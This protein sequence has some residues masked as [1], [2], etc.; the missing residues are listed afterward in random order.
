[1]SNAIPAL[2]KRP[3]LRALAWLMPVLLALPVG[4]ARGLSSEPVESANVTVRLVSATDA[5][6][7]GESLQLGVLLE[8]AP[9]WHTYW[10]NP[11]VAGLTTRLDWTLPEG[12]TAG[13]IA[14]PTPIKFGQEIE[15]IGYGYEGTV[16]L[17]V[18]ID[19]PEDYAGGSLPVTVKVRYLSCAEVCIPGRAEL[20]LEL[21][22]THVASEV[23]P[24]DFADR[25]D[26]AYASMPEANDRQESVSPIA[27]PED[28]GSI[29]LAVPGD[30]IPD[31]AAPEFLPA[32]LDQFDGMADQAVARGT[33]TQGQPWV[34]LRLI[35]TETAKAAPDQV[36]GLVAWGPKDA[37]RSLLIDVA[38]GSDPLELA[39]ATQGDVAAAA[40][41]TTGAGVDRGLMAILGF[42]V[43]GGMILNLMP[44]VFPVLAL[45]ISAFVG[46][47]GESRAAVLKHGLAFGV[48]VLVSFW[49]IAAAVLAIKAGGQEIGWGFQLQNPVFVGAMAIVIFAVG[50]N[51]A[52]VF[53]IGV[54]VMNAAGKASGQVESQ[55][56]LAGSF[57]S[58]V[59]ATALATPCSAPFLATSVGYAMTASAGVLIAVL[60]AMGVGM[61]L[62]YV[63][64]SAF[65]SWLKLL[66]R[67]GA[68]ME[69]FKQF[70][71]FPM[72]AVAAWLVWVFNGQTGGGLGLPGMLGALVL[73]AMG[74][75]ALGRFGVP[76]RGTATR[77]AARLA[78]LA[79]VCSSA[80]TVVWA[81]RPAGEGSLEWQPWSEAA[82]AEARAAGRPVFIDFTAD[83]CA[84]CKFNERVFIDLA[85][86][87][88]AVDRHDVAVFKADWTR[89]DE[90]I[91]AALAEFNVASVP[92]YVF[93]APE[94]GE[95]VV[96]FDSVFSTGKILDA[97]DTVLPDG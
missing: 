95:T 2:W 46:Q 47:A 75:W 56:G 20:S 74:L 61:A 52:G 53:D 23:S 8:H 39:L 77:W 70:M 79:L 13:E 91:T 7:P 25:F 12:V 22:V 36:S 42:A 32:V 80:A 1:M 67:P 48:G 72:F 30:S 73:V 24:S 5:A 69:T 97:I 33:D 10:T 81:G 71:A 31:D 4:V 50:L 94:P 64:L 62:P 63:L 28:N 54:G 90:S 34:R 87:R 58:G 84:T 51:F 9:T 41:G 88:A 40:P 38:V 21:P 68:W 43:L 18:A 29:R 76:S 44:C 82:V 17:P 49:A 83:W 15:I 92:Y 57:G 89:Y 96:H 45:K 93:Y 60:T 85:D 86:V 78:C 16:L 14:W 6:V 19:V 27:W 3:V 26:A 37:R 65:P 55:G 11:G 59:L 66:P 35:S